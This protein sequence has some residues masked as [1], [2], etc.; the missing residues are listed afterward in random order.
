MND[1]EKFVFRLIQTEN[2]KELKENKMKSLICSEIL[3]FKSRVCNRK[4][5]RDFRYPTL[6]PAKHPAINA[7]I[8]DLHR[9]YC[10]VLV[11]GL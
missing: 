8:I 4:D 1:A 11:Q 2:F 6:L 3:R 5:S 7:L 10:H 9:N